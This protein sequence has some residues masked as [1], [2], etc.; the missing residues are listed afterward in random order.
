MRHSCYAGISR[1]CVN[2]AI[3][4]LTDASSTWSAQVHV[5]RSPSTMRCSRVRQAHGRCTGTPPGS[6]LALRRCCPSDGMSCCMMALMQVRPSQPTDRPFL[7]EV[8]RLACALD[9][10]PL[11]AGGDPEVLAIL[12][13]QTD[14]VV[15]AADDA[16][17]PIRGT[18]WHLHSPPLVRDAGGHAVPEVVM[19]VLEVAPGPGD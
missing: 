19:A 12:P 3:S 18:W 15:I 4:C 9:G 17:Q 10:H 11:P 1:A 6:A 14:G 7:I 13:G 16:W 5:M 2:T 8:A